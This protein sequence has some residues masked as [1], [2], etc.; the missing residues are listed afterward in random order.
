[1]AGGNNYLA[2]YHSFRLLPTYSGHSAMHE[3]FA[4]VVVCRGLFDAFLYQ[5]GIG[6]RKEGLE[7]GKS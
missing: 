4:R 6:R 3:M 5:T 2:I 1:M 7:G